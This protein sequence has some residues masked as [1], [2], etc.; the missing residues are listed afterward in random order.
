[1]PTT[2]AVDRR[3]DTITAGAGTTRVRRAR[4]EDIAAIA[5]LSTQLGY[6]VS[7]QDLRGRASSL[8]HSDADALLVAVAPDGRVTGW[9]HVWRRCSVVRDQSAELGGLVVEEAVRR[10]GIG[11]M[12]IE[13]AADW[14]IRAGCRTLRV[15]SNLMRTAS[16]PFYRSVGFREVKRQAVYDIDLGGG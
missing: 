14:A 9:I 7:P 3:P 12:L 8:L 11:R 5:A 15:R 1:M 10:R 13:A 16:H 6:P 2:T 4:R